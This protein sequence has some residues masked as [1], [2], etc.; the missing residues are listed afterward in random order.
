MSAYIY[1]LIRQGE[2]QQLDFK[3][4]I[5]DSKK[6]ARSLAAFANTDGGKLLVGVRDNG[7]IAGVKSDE[8]FYMIQAAA[9]LYCK[10]EVTFE[11]KVWK[12]EGKIL[13]EITIPKLSLDELITAPNK[14]GKFRVYIRV[15]D[16]NFIVNHIYL[17]AWNKKKF[18]KGV[19]V[20]YAEPEKILFDYLENNQKITF[21]K[22][23][24]VA[25]L[26][27]YK[28]EKILINLIVLD[29]IEIV[30]T[31]NQVFYQMA[32]SGIVLD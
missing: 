4:S 32:K 23:M 3:H 22:F 30:F 20:R 26:S 16:Q 9:D 8:E 14:D 5:S 7:S 11:T 17:K 12:I 28:A 24:R 25:Q 21:S 31:E 2:H 1:D 29:I 10:P 27:K 19:L 18:G 6:I 13:L 15:N